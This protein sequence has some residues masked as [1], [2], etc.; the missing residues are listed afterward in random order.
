MERI[1][2]S[3]P[4]LSVGNVMNYFEKLKDPRWQKKR[5]K[6]FERDKWTCQ[7]CGSKTKTLNVHHIEY[8]KGCE[9]WE[10]PL[11]TLITLC[12][13]CHEEET[14]F[15]G[16]EKQLINVLKNHGYTSRHFCFLADDLKAI[17]LNNFHNFEYVLSNLAELDEQ[18]QNHL[19]GEF[20]GMVE[21]KRKTNE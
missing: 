17:K 9:P 8:R 13:D 19:W 3:V 6:V 21:R 10:Y 2:V 1:T 7:M 4:S 20:S 14:I 11:K 15:W 12:E 5:L 18:S 16:A